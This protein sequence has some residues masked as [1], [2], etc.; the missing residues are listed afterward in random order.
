M[1]VL[2]ANYPGIC[3]KNECEIKVGD[4]ILYLGYR[5]SLCEA[6][7]RK[8]YPS[9]FSDTRRDNVALAPSVPSTGGV[10]VLE[11]PV[12][13]PSATRIDFQAAPAPVKTATQPVAD[14]CYARTV[15]ALV[16]PPV[17]PA[18]DARKLTYTRSCYCHLLPKGCGC[19]C[20]YCNAPMY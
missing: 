18:P 1:K 15:E 19:K 2:T 9:Q 14:L 3:R 8:C 7:A 4:T 13:A 12:A 17:A 10:A 6:C 20:G 11:R 5:N 16:A